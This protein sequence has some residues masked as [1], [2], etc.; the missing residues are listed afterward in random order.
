MSRH[1]FNSLRLVIKISFLIITLRRDLKQ[2][3][4]N[5]SYSLS[6]GKIFMAIINETKNPIARVKFG[7]KIGNLAKMFSFVNKDGY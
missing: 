3:K 7:S 1:D 6:G 4:E 5:I 2:E